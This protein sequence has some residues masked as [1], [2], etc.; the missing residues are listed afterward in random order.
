MNTTQL[1]GFWKSLPAVL[2]AIGGC[3]V[4]FGQYYAGWA[5][6]NPDSAAWLGWSSTAMGAVTGV[7]GLFVSAI[8]TNF[9]SKTLPPLPDGEKAVDTVDHLLTLAMQQSLLDKKHSRARELFD[10]LSPPPDEPVS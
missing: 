4:S 2:V 8:N 9:A 5:E 3:L 1:S 7:A 6:A 10:M